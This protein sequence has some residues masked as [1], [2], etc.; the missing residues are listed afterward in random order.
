MLLAMFDLKD[1]VAVVTGA[2]SGIGAAIAQRFAES[3]ARI[4]VAELNSQAGNETVATIRNSGGS[5]E[6]ISVDVASESACQQLGK[7]ILA[8]TDNRCDILVN[9]AGIGHVGTA[10]TTSGE[11]LDRLHAVNV[12]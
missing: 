3:G 2:G 4:F 7:Q 11:D 10:L 5:A 8:A 1:K 9:N 6:F 12:K